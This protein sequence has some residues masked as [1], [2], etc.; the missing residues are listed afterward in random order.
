VPE[1]RAFLARHC[2][3]HFKRPNLRSTQVLQAALRAS[4][5]EFPLKREISVCISDTVA[6]N[7]FG[8]A[9]KIENAFSQILIGRVANGVLTGYESFNQLLGTRTSRGAAVMVGPRLPLTL[10]RGDGE[11]LCGLAA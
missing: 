10:S 2:I 5:L 7:L 11:S 9:K 8:H 1:E 6:F 3:C 4:N